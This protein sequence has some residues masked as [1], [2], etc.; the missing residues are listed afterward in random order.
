[1]R[2]EFSRVIAGRDTAFALESLV[3]SSG[4]GRAVRAGVSDPHD[5]RRC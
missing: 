4:A 3:D 2:A 5:L 1:V